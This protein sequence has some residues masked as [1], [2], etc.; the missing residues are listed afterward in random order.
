MNLLVQCALLFTGGAVLG[1]AAAVVV[2]RVRR[3]RSARGAAQ[4]APPSGAQ[5]ASD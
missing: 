4:P 1:A 3:V 5:P 2:D